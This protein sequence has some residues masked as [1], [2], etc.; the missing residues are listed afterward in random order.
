M[1]QRTSNKVKVYVRTRPTN[2]FA[3]DMIGIGRDNRSISIHRTPSA[4]VVDNKIND[5]IFH[6]D[7]VYN[8][9]S[10]EVIFDSIAK[11]VVDR[12]LD[13]YNGTIMCYG[14]TGAG[15]THTMTGFTESYQNRGII[16]RTLQH[17]YQEINARQDFSFSVRIAYLEIY[18]DQMCDLLRTLNSQSD[19]QQ[20]LQQLSIGEDSGLV[21]VKGL[22]YR[23]ANGEE[24]ALNL[25][26]E[27]ET[28]R[29]I[30]QHVLNKQSSRSHCIFTILIECRSMLSSEDKYTISKL[31]LVDLAGSERLAKTNSEGVTKREA[32]FINKSLSFLEQ[33]V[34]NLSDKK[35]NSHNFRSSKLTHALKD[36]IGG[37]CNTVMIANVWPELQYLEE[38]VSTLRFA[39]RMMC[40]PAEPTVNEVIDPLKALENYKRENKHLREELALHDALINR[41]GISYEPISEQQLY[42]IENQCRRFIDG[43]LDEIEV[44]NLRQVQA[45]FNVFRNICRATEK[46]TEKK[47]HDRHVLSDRYEYEQQ[48]NQK[49]FNVNQG[50]NSMGGTAGDLDGQNFA[51]GTA[52]KDQRVNKDALLKMTRNKRQPAAGATTSKTAGVQQMNTKDKSSPP[53]SKPAGIVLQ[54]GI[55]DDEQFARVKEPSEMLDTKDQRPSTPPGRAAAFEEFKQTRGANLNKIYLENKEIMTTKKKQFAELAR[56]V[57]QTKA[58]IDKTR[59]EAE[60]K[61]NERL[62]MGEF[63]NENGE[64]IIDE[65]EYEFIAKLQELKGTYRADYDQWKNLKSEITY[66]QNLVNQCQN[67]LLQ[68]FDI[69][70]NECYLNKNNPGAMDDL[71]TSNKN[72]NDYR[73]YDDAAERFERMQKELLLSDLDSMPFRQAQMRTNRRHIFDAATTQGPWKQAP[74]TAAVN[75]SGSFHGRTYDQEQQSSPSIS[76]SGNRQKPMVR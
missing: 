17:L 1:P 51:L 64:T 35:N 21:Y 4:S 48:D 15:K 57:N 30:G 34:L 12:S 24:E 36:S 65:E 13:G 29:A 6:F 63:L 25:L 11:D 68:E 50:M 33:A 37:R 43:T 7:G 54:R 2:N 56:R 5:W 60:R 62:T 39:S 38:T 73:V 67:R 3:S 44:K 22:S 8:N 69:W 71:L 72:N 49:M 14:Q 70:Y 9:V 74:S 53:G 28:N 75:N 10:Q 19:Y 40:V 76:T 41:N 55:T 61:K 52:S 45:I 46:D 26:F 58:E 31:N 32:T 27:G 66:C 16:P 18:N 23:I 42:E 47:H 20:Q 59:I